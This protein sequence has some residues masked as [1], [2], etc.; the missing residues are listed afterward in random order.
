MAVRQ[1]TSECIYKG[2]GCVSH[3]LIVRII[4]KALSQA[5]GGS[6]RKTAIAG[7]MWSSGLAR[8][9]CLSPVGCSE[10]KDVGGAGTARRRGGSSCPSVRSIE[11]WMRLS[12]IEVSMGRL[13]WGWLGRYGS[14]VLFLERWCVARVGAARGRGNGVANVGQYRC[15]HARRVSPLALTRK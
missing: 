4:T 6:G 13:E 5:D 9:G 15:R 2:I 8:E 11:E 12:D 1:D 7:H 14:K 10:E 3:S